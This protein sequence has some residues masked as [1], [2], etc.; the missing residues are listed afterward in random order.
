LWGG[1]FMQGCPPAIERPH[2]NAK[3]AAEAAVSNLKH[4]NSLTPLR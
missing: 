2:Q 4:S 3:T 1:V